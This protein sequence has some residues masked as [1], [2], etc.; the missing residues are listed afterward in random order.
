MDM[1]ENGNKLAPNLMIA[2]ESSKDGILLVEIQLTRKF[3]DFLI[4]VLVLDARRNQGNVKNVTVPE[5]T[6]LMCTGISKLI[7][8]WD[9]CENQTLLVIDSHSGKYTI[10]SFDSFVIFTIGQYRINLHDESFVI[11]VFYWS[12]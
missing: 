9:S 7:T 10:G 4:S 6:F 11:F 5:I 1:K 12:S 2:Q 3:I 8:D